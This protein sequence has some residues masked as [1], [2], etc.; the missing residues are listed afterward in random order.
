MADSFDWKLQAVY[1]IV[2]P[3]YM[4]SNGDGMG[5]LTGITSRLDYLA[6]LGV[7]AI[8]LTPFYKT[9]F[10][11]LGYDVVD[12][13]DVDPRFGTLADFDRLVEQAHQLGVRV[14]IDFV[15]NHT[16]ACHA[17]FQEACSSRSSPRRDWY[18]WHDGRG[19]GELPN[20]W[21]N[22]YER[23]TWTWHDATQ[24]Y[25]LHSFHENQPDLNWR[26][27]HLRE[28]MWSVLR[29]WL[30]R[31]VDGFRID[32]MV[33]L[34]KDGLF[35]DN[36]PAPG[37]SVDEWPVWPQTPAYTQ[38]QGDLQS[39]LQELCQVVNEYPEKLLIG[40][41]HLPVERL[42]LYHQSGLSHPVNAQLLD[43]KWEPSHVRR[44]VD[45][46]EGILPEG[47]IP[48]WVLGTH[49]N[50]RVASF[51]GATHVRAAAML[52]LT[53]RGTP[54]VYFGEELGLGNVNLS[55]EHQR[56]PLA[57]LMP[58]RTLGRDY[59]RCPMPWDDSSH[60]GFSTHAPW[61]PLCGDYESVN[62]A[63][64]RDD[65]R[66]V[67]ALYRA[68]LRLRAKEP[69]FGSG[70]YHPLLETRQ[71]FCYLR[72]NQATKFLVAINF[73]S[74]AAEL[75][76]PSARGHLMLSTNLD[77]D[78]ESVDGSLHLRGDEGVVVKLVP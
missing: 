74:E 6:W 37:R 72:E 73:A 10:F 18:L 27:P 58:G 76:L 16:S 78:E 9:E 15:P 64:Q 29:F 5:D 75:Q 65:Q 21:T 51:I 67:L 68:L 20:N 1:Q 36:P 28:A 22:Q 69:V 35:R 52:Q 50:A 26:N 44:I 48:N 8:W 13:C 31:G 63:R 57:R 2:V 24:Q 11:D 47:C 30:E 66:S 39:L 25:Y 7:S 45:R 62:V 61:L 60:A 33:H 3:S 77:R 17:W 23:S 40:E 34:I 42:P 41:N 59:Q 4:D 54:I 19:E 46:Y 38:D 56:D 14:L 49:D 32:A 43:L 71:A 12:H 70:D 53:L 55:D